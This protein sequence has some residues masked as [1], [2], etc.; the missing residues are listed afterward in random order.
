MQI[1]FLT[2]AKLF[3]SPLFLLKIA[4]LV[5]MASFIIFTIV[6]LTQ[7]NVMNKIITHTQASLMLQIIAI[8]NIIF[9]VVLFFIAFVIL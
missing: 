7:V 2:V 8:L 5:I 3:Q 4:L 6:L 1:N 9:A